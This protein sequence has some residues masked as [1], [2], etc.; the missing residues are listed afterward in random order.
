[1]DSIQEYLSPGEQHP[2]SLAWQVH[3]NMFEKDTVPAAIRL[4]YADTEKTDRTRICTLRSDVSG[5]HPR[6]AMEALR[7]RKYDPVDDCQGR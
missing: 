4:H 2:G 5:H 3:T 1:M 6:H 7:F